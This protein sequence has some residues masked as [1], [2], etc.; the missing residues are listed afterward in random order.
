MLEKD[1]LITLKE[2]ADT[3][4]YSQQCFR[5]WNQEGRIEFGW[6]KPKKGKPVIVVSKSDIE[7]VIE[8]W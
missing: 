1:D 4:G 5:N 6:K 8:N 2:A 7:N 3:F